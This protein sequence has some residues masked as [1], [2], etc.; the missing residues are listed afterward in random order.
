MISGFSVLAG[1]PGIPGVPGVPGVPGLSGGNVY[2]GGIG[3]SLGGIGDGDDPYLGGAS[4]GGASVGGKY[5]FST[6][7][8]GGMFS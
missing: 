1:V 5:G 6:E 8:S 2:C 4:V 3:V 7:G